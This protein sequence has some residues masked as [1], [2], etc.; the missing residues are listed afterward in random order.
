MNSPVAG[1][2]A[3]RYAHAKSQWIEPFAYQAQFHGKLIRTELAWALAMFFGV[4][5]TQASVLCEAVELMNTASLIHDDVFDGDHL[6]RG[7]PSVWSTYGVNVAIISGMHGY[8]AGL[9][10]LAVL[11]NVTVMNAGLQS[12]EALHI[13][14]YL[15]VSAS[16]GSVLPTLDEYRLIAQAN[17][18]CFLVFILD[19][20]QSLRPLDALI[21]GTLKTLLYELAVYYRFVNDYCDVNHIP[22]FAKKGFA[23]DLEG[24]PKSFLMI[25]ARRSLAKAKRSSDEKNEIIRAWGDAGVLDLALALMEGEY[26]QLLQSLDLVRRHCA[27]RNTQRLE[28]FIRDIHFQP[29]P[30]DDYYKRILR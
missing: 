30:E 9:Q 2:D 7:Q 15:D 29:E 13:G 8:L 19:V 1:I 26:D 11:D 10:H 4:P 28:A 18:G 17:T 6:R 3:T 5:S 27:K 20:C 12:L 24:G 16:E 14:Q 21:Y 22:H 23:T 25:L